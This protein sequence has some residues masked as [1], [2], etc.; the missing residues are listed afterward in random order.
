M[1]LYA[2]GPASRELYPIIPSRNK[3]ALLLY[4]VAL[5]L[6][7]RVASA[8]LL[9]VLRLVSCILMS[10]NHSIHPTA[11]RSITRQIFRA[12]QPPSTT[13][14]SQITRR[15]FSSH[16]RMDAKFAPAKRVA[17]QKQDVWSIVNEAA[18][19]SPVQPIVNMG[20]GFL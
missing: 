7:S 9:D 13:I 3:P 1:I 8:V 16:L 20:Q 19:A 11:I 4:F 15:T 10:F 5:C 18:A 6:P 14:C 17:G 2:G 12:E